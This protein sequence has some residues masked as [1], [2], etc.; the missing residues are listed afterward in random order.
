MY[1]DYDFVLWFFVI[2]ET[3]GTLVHLDYD[4]VL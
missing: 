4:L 2:V 3:L 1:L